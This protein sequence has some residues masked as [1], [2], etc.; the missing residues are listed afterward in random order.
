MHRQKPF[1]FYILFLVITLLTLTAFFNVKAEEAEKTMALQGVMQ[2][3]GNNMQVVAGA[4]SKE[5]WDLVAELSPKIA[6]HAEP[7]LSEKMRILA[8]LG[9]DAGDFRNFDAQV[10]DAAI[11]MGNAATQDDGQAVIDSFARVQQSCL[12]CHQSFRKPFQ[13]FFYEQR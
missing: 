10:H 9:K 3:L 6:N 12:A 7:P 5:D 2:K 13:R 4:I 1:P 8:W 11:S